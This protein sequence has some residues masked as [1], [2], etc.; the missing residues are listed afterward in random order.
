[1]G[2]YVLAVVLGFA[3]WVA[4]IH[5]ASDIVRLENRLLWA[6]LL[7]GVYLLGSVLLRN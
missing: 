7:P 4:V 1:M 6:A 5:Q 2:R 3:G